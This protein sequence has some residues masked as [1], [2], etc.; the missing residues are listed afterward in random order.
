M[1]REPMNGSFAEV[2]AAI[3]LVCFSQHWIF[4]WLNYEKWIECFIVYGKEFSVMVL[5]E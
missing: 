5:C 2:P 1:V 3:L 4:H